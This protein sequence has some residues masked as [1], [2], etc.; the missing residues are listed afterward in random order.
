MYWKQWGKKKFSWDFNGM[1]HG[2]KTSFSSVWERTFVYGPWFQF[3][4]CWKITQQMLCFPLLFSKSSVFSS[5]KHFVFWAVF[6]KQ[7]NKETIWLPNK[8]CNLLAVFQT[9]AGWCLL[10]LHSLCE[11]KSEFEWSQTLVKDGGVMPLV[12]Q[13]TNSVPLGGRGGSGG[14]WST[15]ITHVT[16]NLFICDF[17]TFH[18]WSA[19]SPKMAVLIR[20]HQSAVSL[21]NELTSRVMWAWKSQQKGK[22]MK[23]RGHP[24]PECRRFC[25]HNRY[26][27]KVWGH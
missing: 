8:S 22:K 3:Q 9:L 20:A 1:S 13:A 2:F 7:L 15:E 6:P 14:G 5:L 23:F 16:V 24:S 19:C 18:S 17:K 10:F 21:R 4:F 11:G 25:H 12:R 26:C 27:S